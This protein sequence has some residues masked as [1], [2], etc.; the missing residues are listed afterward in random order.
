MPELDDIEL[1]AQYARDQS[2][3]A[4]AALVTRHVNLV[5]S[6][7][8]RSAG[9][10]HAAEEITQAVFIILARKARNLSPRTILSGWLY[11]TARLTAANF[12]RTEIRRQ[13]REQEAYMQSLLNVPEP[14]VWPQIAPLLDAAMARLGEKDRNAVVLRFF[15][16][17][18]L[19]EVGQALGASEDAAKMRVN[20][21]LE[22]LRKFFAR[23]GAVLPVALIAGAVSANS[24]HAAPAGMAISVTATAAKGSAAAASTLTLVKGALKL[25]AWTKMKTAAVAG[26]VI[27]LTAG[28]GLIAVKTVH[29]VRSA[30]APDIQGAWAGNFEF[31]D[32]KMPLMYKITREN[33]SY[34]AV[35]VDVY[36]GVR[37]APVSKLVYDYP[38]IRIEQKGIGFTYDATLNPKTM[39]MSGTWKQNGGSGPF[40]MKLNALADAF[41]EPMAESDYAPR[42]DSDLQGYWKGT[43]KAGNT[44]LRVALKIAERADGTFRATGDS[45]DQGSKDVEASSVTYHRPTVRV[46]FGGI[47]G[48]FEG[49]V[50]DSDRVITGSLTQ[51]GKPMP[52]TLERA[53]PETAAVSDEATDAQKDYT[54]T[55]P[56]DLQGHWQGTLEVKQADVKLRLALNVAKLP[57]GKFS[58]TMIS[59]DQGSGEIPASRVQYIAPNVSMEWGALGA[60]FHGKLENGKLTGAWRQG[61]GALPLV[62]ERNRAQ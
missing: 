49:A 23:R 48:V 5:Y 56:N 57:D 15:E 35:E 36:Q 21:A 29:A 14:D 24:V 26:A 51:G 46:E 62:L 10:V 28:T 41:P 32:Q 1:L 61:G 18:S 11:H 4:F 45:P 12:L 2:E 16:N 53:R 42:K 55:S 44:M 20:R 9:N 13:H 25:M 19:G 47:S 17:K 54:Y 40:T 60:A 37:E 39:E 33:G 3:V 34:H 7:A 43:L 38:S 27:L 58:C 31:K 30:Y 52:L 8:L 22:K 50:D 59:L 6:T